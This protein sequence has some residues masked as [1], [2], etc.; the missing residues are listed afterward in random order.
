M[1]EDSALRAPAVIGIWKRQLAIKVHRRKHMAGASRAVCTWVGGG[2]RAAVEPSGVRTGG[3][4]SP[5]WTGQMFTSRLRN[6]VARFGHERAAKLGMHG[7]RRGAAQT[8]LE[9][10]GAFAQMLMAGQ[11]HLPAYRL[12]LDL[13][14]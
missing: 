8:I 13:V 4:L 14:A 1:G 10:V 6:P 9:S 2:T 5:S 12:N 7:V 11:W 3:R